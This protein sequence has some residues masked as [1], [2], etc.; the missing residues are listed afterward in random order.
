MIADIG[1]TLIVLGVLLACCAVSVGASW[2]AR[3][4]RRNRS[5]IWRVR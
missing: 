1:L 2:L 3:R 4:W 5:T